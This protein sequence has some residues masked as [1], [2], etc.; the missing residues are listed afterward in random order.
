MPDTG[1][2][3]RNKKLAKYAQIPVLM[4]PNAYWKRHLNSLT[5]RQLQSDKQYG[6]KSQ[7][8]VRAHSAGSGGTKL[9]LEQQGGLS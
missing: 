4:G 5:N 9:S 6:G 1:E 7:C 8:A 2:G 3:V